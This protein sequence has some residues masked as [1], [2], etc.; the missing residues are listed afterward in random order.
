MG[1][2]NSILLRPFLFKWQYRSTT[3]H[4]PR[5]T[6]TIG[7][8]MA[9]HN[10]KDRAFLVLPLFKHFRHLNLKLLRRSPVNIEVVKG[11]FEADGSLLYP[12][13]MSASLFLLGTYNLNRRNKE[14]YQ[15]EYLFN[16]AELLIEP[17][18]AN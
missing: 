10:H 4:T 1:G 18:I 8:H 6:I 3:T 2:S 11:F 15:F 13:V 17:M 16:L 14:Y 9:A 5:G 12:V 7:E